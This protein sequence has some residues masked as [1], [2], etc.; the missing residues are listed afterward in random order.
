MHMGY[1]SGTYSNDQGFNFN[2][3]RVNRKCYVQCTEA[4][5]LT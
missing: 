3:Q 4:M 1:A 2:K 5:C